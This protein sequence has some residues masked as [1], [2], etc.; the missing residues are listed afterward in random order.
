KR[1]EDFADQWIVRCYETEGR[2]CNDLLPIGSTLKIETPFLYQLTTQVNLL[3][4][5]VSGNLTTINL[6][7]ITS[8]LLTGEQY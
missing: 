7:Q 6:W 1:H 4:E 5:K 2:A 3:E 8:F